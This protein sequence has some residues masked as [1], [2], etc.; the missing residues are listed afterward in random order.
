MSWAEPVYERGRWQVISQSSRPLGVSVLGPRCCHT[1]A[2]RLPMDRDGGGAHMKRLG[3]EGHVSLH[4]VSE[5]RERHQ[6][7]SASA[8]VQLEE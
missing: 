2:S 8:Q 4:C 1:I 3:E 7:C 5:Q 6:T